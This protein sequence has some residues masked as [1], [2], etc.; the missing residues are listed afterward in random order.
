VPDGFV[1]EN[2]GRRCR[3][4]TLGGVEI[5]AADGGQRNLN[6]HFAGVEF[7]GEGDRAHLKW[8]VGTLK[9]L[10]AG[11]IFLTES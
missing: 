11:V 5:G 8:L 6:E 1:A 4:T 3:A 9:K 10:D 2:T 7:I